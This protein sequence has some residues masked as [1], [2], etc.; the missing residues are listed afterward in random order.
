MADKMAGQVG[1]TSRW[2]LMSTSAVAKA[3]KADK[4]GSKHCR[5]N[6]KHSLF[7]HKPWFTR[8]Q[9]MT[10]CPLTAS[11]AS[12]FCGKKLPLITTVGRES[13]EP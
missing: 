3:A 5:A 9:P 2:A 7:A 4:E 12:D 8:R 10:G 6:S 11:P 1:A 13:L